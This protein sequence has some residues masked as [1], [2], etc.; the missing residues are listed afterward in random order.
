MDTGDKPR[1]DNSKKQPSAASFSWRGVL[2]GR[3]RACN[4][5]RQGG[6]A[7]RRACCVHEQLNL[8]TDI[9]GIRVGHA[10]NTRVASG[11][12]VALI[13]TPCVV[14][15]VTRGGAPG[16]RDTSLLEPEM[17]VAAVDAVVL[18]GGSL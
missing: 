18:S 1:Y 15:G 6:H 17:T 14:S 13:D 9:A 4:V 8:I 10:Q 7:S 11:V 12:T 5:R 2:T 3:Q 16:S